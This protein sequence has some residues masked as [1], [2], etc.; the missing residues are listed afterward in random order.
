MTRIGF[1]AWAA[2]AVG[3][4]EPVA[5]A[6]PA[7]ADSTT[8]PATGPAFVNLQRFDATSRAG[9]QVTQLDPFDF[10]VRRRW[11]V[12][13]QWVERT[14]RIG[15]YLRLPYMTEKDQDV[16]APVTHSSAFGNL[17]LGAIWLP[18]VGTRQMALVV[19]AGIAL[20]SGAEEHTY[21]FKSTITRPNE[22]SSVFTHWVTASVGASLL[23]TSNHVFARIDGGIELP[24]LS[25]DAR[26]PPDLVAIHGN[27]GLGFRA[28][29]VSIGGELSTV[30]LISDQ[31]HIF[32]STSS[33]GTDMFGALGLSVR[34]RTR[35]VEPYAAFVIPMEERQRNWMPRAVV[36]GIEA[37][38]P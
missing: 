38:L 32:G 13:G 28:G 17:A 20:P 7:S 35:W 36:L 9:V 8:D 14:H 6:Q 10:T 5:R 25:T 24:F 1:L 29:P 4:V 34:Y 3:A 16:D 37:V 15:G 12:F 22:L 31:S 21:L 30:T 2:L 18:R 27:A 11:E 19:H 33:E 26:Y 23:F